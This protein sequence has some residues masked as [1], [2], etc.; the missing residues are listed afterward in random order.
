[1]S[2]KEDFYD[3]EIAPVLLDLANK[4]AERGL[5]FLAQVEYEPGEFGLTH[6]FADDPHLAMIMLALCARA[7]HNVDSYLIGLMR[8]CHENKI[9]F[10]ASM[11][12]RQYARDP[13]PSITW[14]DWA[15]D[16]LKVCPRCAKKAAQAAAPKKP[17]YDDLLAE[18]HLLEEVCAF[19]A[20]DEDRYLN[21]GEPYCIPTE[22]GMK[23]RSARQ[24]FLDRE[25]LQSN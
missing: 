13:E 16:R 6:K 22:V 7:K 1:M 11:I 17:A 20:N 4:C 14:S 15:P 9:D 21:G 18:V 5:H 12:L 3:G 25:K 2:A 19:Y 23:A 8:Y 24:R 10:S